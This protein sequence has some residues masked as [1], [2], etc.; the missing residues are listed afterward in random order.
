M[1]EMEKV[2][3]SPK[4]RFSTGPYA[5]EGTRGMLEHTALTSMRDALTNKNI[6]LLTTREINTMIE[7]WR[8]NPNTVEPLA[9]MQSVLE[10]VRKIPR[11]D[12]R[13]ILMNSIVRA[14][15]RPDTLATFLDMLRDAATR[16]GTKEQ[17]LCRLKLQKV[18]M[19]SIYGWCGNTLLV[20]SFD[21][22]TEGTY[23]PIPGLGERLGN[24]TSAWNLTVHIW[25]PNL[26]AKGF[27]INAPLEKGTLLEP[28]H[29][30]PFDFVSTVVKGVMRQ[31]IY[32]QND[33]IGLTSTNSDD[34]YGQTTLEHVDG[35]WPPHD[36]R[37]ARTLKT[38]EHRVLLK[39]GD[40]YHLP[41]DWIHDVEI[42][43]SIAVS[44]PTITLFLSSEYM[45][46][47]HV[48]MTKAMADFHDENPDIKRNGVPI[49]ETAW[50]DKL[51]A[52][53]RYLRSESATLDLNEI[54]K[55][56]GEYAFFHVNS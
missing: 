5:P 2:R 32:A 6:D 29:S 45:V 54:V 7:R 44:K 26:T 56:P 13:I 49:A 37:E 18:R 16:D 8:N 11:S 1:L 33:D 15:G 42:D 53:A 52:I 20:E 12:E 35:V 21:G 28:P 22:P 30:H 39:E 23:K 41:C 19:H 36:L 40:S 31:S 48:Y 34:R 17:E 9:E 27:P 55:Y 3:T 10:R 43:G 50:H 24:S 4:I 46:M 51:K 47:P 14:L 25:Q 38:L